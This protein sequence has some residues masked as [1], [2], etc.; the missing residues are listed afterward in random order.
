VPLP[1]EC[2]QF[3]GFGIIQPGGGVAARAHMIGLR[4]TTGIAADVVPRAGM[5]LS[6]SVDRMEQIRC[7]LF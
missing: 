6:R 4:A 1:S 7:D 3:L 5:I 2:L